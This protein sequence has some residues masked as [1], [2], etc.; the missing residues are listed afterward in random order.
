MQF[1]TIIIIVLGKFILALLN[2]KCAQHSAV[3]IEINRSSRRIA[4][5][6]IKEIIQ[7][8]CNF[9]WIVRM[10]IAKDQCGIMVIQT[11]TVLYPG[12]FFHGYNSLP[13][14]VV[15]KRNLCRYVFGGLSLHPDTFLIRSGC[16]WTSVVML[17]IVTYNQAS[18]VHMSVR[19][20]F[21]NRIVLSVWRH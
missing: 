6:V 13:H 1:I 4:T 9:A 15:S 20:T 5:I 11:R 17:Q 18:M 19:W 14:D 12:R 3:T 21:E 16:V 2:V 10:I 8:L 7:C